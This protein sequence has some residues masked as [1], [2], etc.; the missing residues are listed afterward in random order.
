MNVFKLATKTKIIL[1]LPPNKNVH[2][3]TI[4][5]SDYVH[6]VPIDCYTVQYEVVGKNV[7][8]ECSYNNDNSNYTSFAWDFDREKHETSK[9]KNIT[10]ARIL[11][12]SIE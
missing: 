4:G 12:F 8:V 3:A 7:E 9:I 10:T 2:F 6:D 5:L 1:P 11:F